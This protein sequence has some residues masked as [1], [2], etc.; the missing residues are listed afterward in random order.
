MPPNKA[1]WLTASKAK[2][3]EVKDAPY[4]AAEADQIVIQNHAV[5]INLIDWKKQDGGDMV[6]P[7]IKHPFILGSDVAGEVIEVG[8]SLSRFTIGDRVV[9]FALGQSK[10]V[11]NHAQSGFQTYTVLL[12][13]M[14]SPIPN[15]MSYEQASVLPMGVSTAA[16][17]L[18]GKDSLALQ[19]PSL[20]PKPT[21][22][23][24]LIWGG[25]TSVGSNAIQLAVAAGY[26]VITTASPKN[27]DYVRKLG[28]SQAFDYKSK[29]VVADIIR[30]FQ[31]R[32]IAGALS[33]GTGAADACFDVL[34]KCEGDKILSM[35][36]YPVP[37]IFPKYFTI[38]RVI[39]AYGTGLLSIWFKSRTR[40][41]RA[42][43]LDLSSLS[44]DG[45]GKAVYQDF[46]S[47]ALM[48]GTYLAVPEPHVIGTG[49][50]NIQ[51]A[52]E[53]HKNGVSAKKIVVSL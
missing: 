29:T 43:L 48:N 9:G 44:N 51:G 4:T 3:L 46:L 8:N 47:K 21:G 39:Y 16:G 22:K 50:E 52:F 27:F 7:W 49:L 45:V 20:S 18:F 24:V 12:D 10:S 34:N 37:D 2:P 35:A 23:T 30:A 32:I 11:N 15:S 19:L 42:T 38:P 26:E 14:A 13:H 41:I 33:I 36:T 6:F 1:A 25:S 40:G 28:A 5:A 31:G 53:I 17:G